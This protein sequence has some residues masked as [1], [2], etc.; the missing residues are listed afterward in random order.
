M[1]KL[2]SPF[3]RAYNGFSNLNKRCHMIDLYIRVNKIKFST[4]RTYEL[5]RFMLNEES[6]L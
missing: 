1:E 6:A 4:E 3:L 2:E 5:K